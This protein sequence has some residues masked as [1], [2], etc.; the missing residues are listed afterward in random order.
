MFATTDM[1]VRCAS[2][3]KHADIQL[4]KPKAAIEVKNIRVQ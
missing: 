4:T 3:M 2:N 1:S